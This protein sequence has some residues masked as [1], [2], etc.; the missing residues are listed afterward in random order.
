[1]AF[2]DSFRNQSWL[3]PPSIEELIPEDHICFLV[4]NF[5]D[6]LD[7]T[8]FEEK[9]AGAG[10][11]AYHPRILLKLLVMGVL[12]K[13]RSSRRLGRNAKENVVYM[14]LAEKL[15]P[16]FRTLSDFRKNN[17]DLIKMV[18]KHTVS[19]AKDEGM[20]DLSHFSTDGTKIKANAANKRIFT[21]KELK[22][23]IN[24][25]ND[26]LEEW[27]KQDELE[28]DFFEEL[29]GS[30]QLPKS[31]KK[32]VKSAVKHYI[33]N[34]KENGELFKK[35][36]IGSIEKAHYELEKNGLEKV[37]ITDP[38]SRFMLSKK[39][40]I[41]LSYNPQITTESNGF[42]L[43]NDVSNSENDSNQLK[44]QVIQTEEN[45]GEI[46][47]EVKWSFDN[48]YFEGDNLNFIK[49]KEIDGYISGQKK[50]REKPYDKSN[51]A[52][53]ES[54]DAY[55]CPEKKLLPFLREYYD[56]NRKKVIRR[57]KGVACE[58]CIQQKSCTKT[59]EGIRIIKMYP[60]EKERKA[61]EEKMQTSEA[62]E[63]YKLRKLIVEPV[64][65]DIKENKGVTSFLTRGLKTVKT[66]FNLICSGNNIKRFHKK[67]QN[68]KQQVV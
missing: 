35:N 24:F 22:F 33:E 1:M 37:S 30:D 63:I 28:D 11:P 20:L 60:Y 18:F 42:I 19:L 34:L 68:L 62:K 44:P 61:M 3:L 55:I 6:S 52:Y 14:Y 53:N 43:S 31:S 13:V 15:A 36:L 67:K 38:E 8:T 50:N 46:P 51:F 9:Y 58:K 57:Y 66:E 2:I 10:H 64:F 21:E 41:E 5:M 23:I 29:R 26:E 7:Y 32:R 12:D 4:E 48:S 56:K 39:G 17:P 65:G 45:F 47:E 54:K 59:K 27:A 40:K 49:D 25:I 16:D